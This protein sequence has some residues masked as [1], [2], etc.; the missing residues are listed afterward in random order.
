MLRAEPSLREPSLLLPSWAFP[1]KAR[2]T[3]EIDRAS[4][5]RLWRSALQR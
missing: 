5:L 1:G 2:S 3:N 4:L